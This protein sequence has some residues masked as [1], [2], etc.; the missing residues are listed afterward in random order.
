[1]AK[2]L[3]IRMDVKVKFKQPRAEPW[4]TIYTDRIPSDAPLFGE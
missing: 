1:M 3:R 4:R 2:K